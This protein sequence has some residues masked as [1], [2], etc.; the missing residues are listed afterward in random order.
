ML[1]ATKI[2]QEK[3]GRREDLDIGGQIRKT[4]LEPAI[5]KS[6]TNADAA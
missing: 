5:N 2:H 6:Q 4:M 1:A 3:I